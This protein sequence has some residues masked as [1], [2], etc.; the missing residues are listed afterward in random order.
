MLFS[1]HPVIKPHDISHEFIKDC[2]H[3]HSIRRCYVV[4]LIPYLSTLSHEV[5]DGKMI[6]IK[7]FI[8][9]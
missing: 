5:T 1:S 4:L 6:M 3:F 9:M 2:V 7:Q 8:R